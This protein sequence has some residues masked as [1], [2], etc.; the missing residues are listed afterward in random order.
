VAVIVLLA[1][2]PFAGDAEGLVVAALLTA[3]LAAL[4]VAEQ[5]RGAH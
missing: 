3:L 4:V 2:V 5:L 1:A